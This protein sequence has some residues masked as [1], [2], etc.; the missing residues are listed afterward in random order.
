MK[1]VKVDAIPFAPKFAGEGFVS[2]LWRLTELDNAVVRLETSDGAVGWGEIGR[3]PPLAEKMRAFE[4]EMLPSLVG[5]EVAD[6]PARLEEWRAAGKHGQCVAFG[7]ELAMLD[8]IGRAC[9][10]P[11]SALLGG[12]AGGD[13]PEY[14]SLSAGVPEEMAVRVRHE[15][16][17]YPVIQVKLGTDDIDTDLK[18]VHA[19]LAEIR[20]DQKVLADFNGALALDD[21]TRTLPLCTDPRLLW[22]EP[23][24]TYD[25]NLEVARQTGIGVMVDQCLV[26]LET[27]L[28]AVKDGMAA[29]AIKPDLLGGLCPARIV[30]DMCRA[31]RIPMRIDGRWSGQIAGVGQLH[32]A[33]GAPADLLLATID[34]T[35]PIETGR[36][37]IRHP[38][39]GRVGPNPGPGLGPIPGHVISGNPK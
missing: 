5:F 7:V 27:N 29:I 28:R 1:I 20:P 33:L 39:P 2:S 19:V 37:M 30:R 13:M 31:A 4:A 21:A 35:E 3:P 6:L 34:L 9:S 17:N 10:M 24:R 12:P 16:V 8:L 36:E 15:G 38:A 32:L 22:E 25:D 23:C 11:I 26:D 14:L 18:R